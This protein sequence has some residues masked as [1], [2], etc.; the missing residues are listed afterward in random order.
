M[1]NPMPM[2]HEVQDRF[3]EVQGE[4]RLVELVYTVQCR[5]RTRQAR[6]ICKVPPVSFRYTFSEVAAVQL[7]QVSAAYRS[8]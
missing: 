4:A 8:L 5:C 6:L 3:D 2:R 1:P 7:H